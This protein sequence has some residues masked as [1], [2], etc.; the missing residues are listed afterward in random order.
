MVDTDDEA[1]VADG[2]AWW[3]ALMAAGG[4]GMVVKPLVNLDPDRRRLA[5]PGV[6]VRGRE[7]LR[8][9][10]GPDYTE[11]LNLERPRAR[12]L[13]HKRNLALREYAPGLEALQRTVAGEPMWRVHEA[14]FAILALESEPVDPR[15]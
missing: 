7:Y 5:Q 11:P 9:I 3:E 6:K 4:E 12:N 13:G 14:V 10:D 15:L 2:V 8:I 1:S